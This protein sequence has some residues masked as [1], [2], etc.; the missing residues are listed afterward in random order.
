M[1][2][3]NLFSTQRKLNLNL[4]FHPGVLLSCGILLVRKMAVGVGQL[5]KIHCNATSRTVRLL[6]V[7]YEIPTFLWYET[8]PQPLRAMQPAGDLAGNI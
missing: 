5:A 8:A 3:S 7:S 1:V 2:F 4:H 6:P